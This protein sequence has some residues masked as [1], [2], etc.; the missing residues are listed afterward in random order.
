MNG[1]RSSS[2]RRLADVESPARAPSEGEA[3]QVFVC[4][5]VEHDGE[6]YELLLAQSRA[7]GS[8][9]TV[10]GRS[11]RTA[12]TDV[13]GDRVRGCIRDADQVIVI[14]SEHTAASLRV[15]AELHMAQQE[16]TPYILLWGRREIMCTKP[17]GATSAEGMYSWTRQILQEQ[18][19]FTSRKAVAAAVPAL[20]A[21]R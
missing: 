2:L 5:D 20:D 1:D 4:F 10:S 15:S 21:S 8:N 7:A 17:I 14:C 11:E 3:I 6:L 9:F 19:R 12:A 18:I 13:W 16:G